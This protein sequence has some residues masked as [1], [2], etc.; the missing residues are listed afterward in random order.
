MQE[1]FVLKLTDF[2]FTI[3][4][5]KIYLSIIQAGKTCVDR[6]AKNTQLH[7]QD[8]YKLLPKLE[9]MGLITR[10]IDK[11]FMVEALP[12]ERSLGGLIVKEK[13][14]LGHRIAK[15]E[16]H[17]KEMSE[18]IQQQPEMYEE[19]RF[20][21]LTTNVAVESRCEAI[22]KKK[23]KRFMIV[24]TFEGLRSRVGIYYREFLQIAA[25]N[26]VKVKLIVVGQEDFVELGKLIEKFVPDNG[27]FEVKAV[28]SCSSK[29]YLVVDDGE[30]WILTRQKTRRGC[31]VVFW[32]ND[33]NIVDFY[34][35]DFEDCW[36]SSRSVTIYQTKMQREAVSMM[37][38]TPFIPQFIPT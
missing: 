37:K 38:S 20:V 9:K 11:P 29:G 6:I 14:R 18:E 13:S 10:T 26:G 21:L 24:S 1:D 23:P 19:S 5:A 2:G 8:I 36:N 22:F 12:F 16:K 34:L 35:E 17:L 7:K 31:P 28:G 30:V 4:Q 27:D 3:N 15:L 33:L 25:D 32:T